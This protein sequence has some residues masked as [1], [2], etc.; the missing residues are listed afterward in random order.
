VV[1]ALA[2]AGQGNIGTPDIVDM[3][4]CAKMAWETIMEKAP[5]NAEQVR[6]LNNQTLSAARDTD[7]REGM[8]PGPGYSDGPPWEDAP[9]PTSAD[10]Y[11]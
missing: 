7:T 2:A 4:S 3:L 1:E 9:L 8:A 6:D 11:R 5:P 10:D